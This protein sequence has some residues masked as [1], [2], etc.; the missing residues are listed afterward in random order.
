MDR[1]DAGR[2]GLARRIGLGRCGLARTVG[3]AWDGQG[4]VV[5]LDRVDQGGTGGE[6]FGSS[7]WLGSGWHGL[8]R[9]GLGGF[10][11]LGGVVGMTWTGMGRHVALDRA[12]AG[13][14]GLARRIGGDGMAWHVGLE[15]YG[16]AGIVGLAWAGSAWVGTSDWLGKGGKEGARNVRLAWPGTAW[17]V[18]WLVLGRDGPVRP[19]GLGGH[20]SGRY[21]RS[22]RI[23]LARPGTDWFVTWPVSRFPFYLPCLPCPFYHPRLISGPAPSPVRVCRTSLRPRHGWCPNRSP[24]QPS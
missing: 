12:D 8:G 23:G 15:R 19:V 4:R 1:A 17:L 3:L 16:M 21:G 14:P 7:D 18:D 6:R 5:G 11:G 10:G 22:R 9:S 24:W 13:R 20:R 2:P